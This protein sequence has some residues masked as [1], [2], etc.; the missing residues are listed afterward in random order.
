MK[1]CNKCKEEKPGT[2]FYGHNSTRDGLS[3]SCKKCVKE[4]SRKWREK[5]PKPP[6]PRKEVQTGFRILPEGMRKCGKCREIKKKD[7]FYVDSSRASGVSN[8]CKK[9]TNEYFKI[10]REERPMEGLVVR[11]EWASNN[12]EKLREQARAYAAANRDRRSLSESR[13]RARK[14]NLPDTLTIPEI[15]VIL[16]EFKDKCSICSNTYEHLDHFI[17][18]ASGHGGTT[19]E[20]IVPMC[21]KCNISKGAKNPFVW[22]DTLSEKDRERFDSLVKYLTKINGIATVENY[23]AHV[24][25]C[26]K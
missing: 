5:N 19:Y 2:E 24:T 21:S 20:N 22:A 10:R 25:N 17:P 7:K 16:N 9:C 26:F 4:R 23:E 13:R 8:R 1:V 6:K 18:V 12:R 15:E 3:S 14:A 11:R